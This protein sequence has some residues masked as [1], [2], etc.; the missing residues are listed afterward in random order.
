MKYL[1]LCIAYKVM[2]TYPKNGTRYDR[3]VLQ[4]YLAL[5][6]ITPRLPHP[7]LQDIYIISQHVC[8]VRDWTDQDDQ[9]RA[10]LRVH[11]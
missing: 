10:S 4:E 2:M 1:G 7:S 9:S 11:T 3:R 8:I 5:A 6:G